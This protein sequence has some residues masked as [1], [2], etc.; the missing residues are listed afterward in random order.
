MIGKDG[1][2]SGTPVQEPYSA[3][4]EPVMPDP[5]L[6]PEARDAIGQAL[7]RAYDSLLK[8]PIPEKISMLLDSIARSERKS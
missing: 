8:E 7:R 6:N 2:D 4:D 5:A 3:T 1:S